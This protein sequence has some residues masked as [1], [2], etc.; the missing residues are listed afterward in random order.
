MPY[1]K[2]HLT[3]DSVGVNPWCG[4]FGEVSKWQSRYGTNYLSVVD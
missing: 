1:T 4:L 3:H 2:G